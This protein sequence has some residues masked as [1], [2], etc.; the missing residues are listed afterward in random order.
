MRT[1]IGVLIASILLTTAWTHANAQ[2][3]SEPPA[4]NLSFSEIQARMRGRDVSDA[5][6]L[7]IAA[8]AVE[9]AELSTGNYDYR[10]FMKRTPIEDAHDIY[11]PAEIVSFSYELVDTEPDP[12][13]PVIFLFNGGP[14]SASIWLH[15]AGFGPDKTSAEFSGGPSGEVTLSRGANGGFLID[16]ADLVFVDP[17]GTGL[18]RVTDG[19]D[20]LKFRDLRVDARAMCRFAQNWL[21][22]EDRGDAPVYVLG[23]S[24]STL[25]AAGMASHNSCRD[26]RQELRGLIFVSGLL[27]LRMRHPRDVTGRVSP[28]PTIAAI[29]WNRGLI[30][31]TLWPG[32]LQMFLDE[33]ESYADTTLRPAMIEGRRLALPERRAIINE[34]H[35]QLGIAPPSET[36]VSIA[37][38]IQNARRNVDGNAAACPYDARFDCRRTF[39]SHPDL[40]LLAFGDRLETELAA[41]LSRK[42]NYELAT[43]HYTVMRENLFRAN[44]DY[45]FHKSAERG[46]GTDMAHTLV[47]KIRLPEPIPSVVEI[48]SLNDLVAYFKG[49]RTAGKNTTRIMVASGIHDLVTPYYA[50]ELALL[51]AGLEPSQFEMRLYEGGHMMYLE[52]E[53]GYQLAADIRSFVLSGEKRF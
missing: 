14:G 16:V 21:A 36:I 43:D 5:S 12:S 8:S 7:Q 52:K 6:N 28:Y 30:D 45:R 26:F 37:A 42:M 20:D 53:T 49:R 33:M 32:G 15:M 41:Y 31:H 17:V 2:E 23:V 35:T 27:D 48:A 19:T 22:A 29:A 4:A 11:P 40:P 18:S 47:R 34:L 50:M 44:W 39:G 51:N 46:A 13:R 38:G 1:L 24:Y 3:T 25:R 10:A 9:T